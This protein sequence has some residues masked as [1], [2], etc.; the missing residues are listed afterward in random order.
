MDQEPHPMTLDNRRAL[1]GLLAIAAVVAGFMLFQPSA[2]GGDFTFEE[3]DIDC[4]KIALFEADVVE[5]G[6]PVAFEVLCNLTGVPLKPGTVDSVIFDTP[7][8][9]DTLPDNF[10]IQ[11]VTCFF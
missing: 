3:A 7:S 6:E 10:A 1:G 8:I 11:S 4:D 2:Q 5:L 9:V